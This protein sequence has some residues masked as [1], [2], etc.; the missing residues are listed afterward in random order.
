MVFCTVQV[1][2]ERGL[3]FKGITMVKMWIKEAIKSPGSLKKSLHVKKGEKIL[4][5]KLEKATHA[6]GKLGQKARLAET[7]KHFKKK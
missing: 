3:W 5:E 7:L 6:K 2:K 1:S 4:E